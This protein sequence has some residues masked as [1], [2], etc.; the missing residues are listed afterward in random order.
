MKKFSPTQELAYWFVTEFLEEEWS[1]QIH[2]RYLKEAERFLNPKKVDPLTG[3]PQK[4]YS[5]QTIMGCLNAMRSGYFGTPILNIGT[6][7]AVTWRNRKTGHSFLEDW[8]EIPLLPPTY[9]RMEL[10]AWVDAYGE[11]AVALQAITENELEM[12]KAV[13]FPHA[14]K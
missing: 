8:L 11:R 10:G 7:H 6:I 1:W 4:S 14:G 3:E 9:R 5:A 12:L 2:G 13:A